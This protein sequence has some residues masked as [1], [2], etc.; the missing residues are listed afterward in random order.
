MP[1]L[2]TGMRYTAV[3]T[4]SSTKE[5]TVHYNILDAFSAGLRRGSLIHTTGY[6]RQVILL[7]LEVMFLQVGGVDSGDG[8][9]KLVETPS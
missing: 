2:V 6:Y 5:P 7:G 3:R 8:I 9:R 4:H 1:D